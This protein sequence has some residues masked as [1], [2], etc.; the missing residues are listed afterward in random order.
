MIDPFYTENWYI[1]SHT[2]PTCAI[3][4]L[5][6]PSQM[7]TSWSST[8]F[9]LH[10]EV[11]TQK[12]SF[13]DSQRDRISFI[14]N[15]GATHTFHTQPA[16]IILYLRKQALAST[17]RSLS[18]ITFHP[19]SSTKL[20][21]NRRYDFFPTVFKDSPCAEISWCVIFERESW[22]PVFNSRSF[23]PFP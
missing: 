17:D 21:L 13:R 20:T 3:S 9:H 22:K 7:L 18:K 4:F 14:A 12:S 11:S 16:T 6:N 2:T 8:S 19:N 10:S 1:F 5:V 23:V 15:S